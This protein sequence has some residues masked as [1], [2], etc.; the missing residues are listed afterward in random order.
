MAKDTRTYADR[1][2]YNIKAVSKRRKK[3]KEMAV[4]YKGGKCIVCNYSRYIG[5]LDFHHVDESDKEFSLSV[6]GLTR[7]WQRI[8]IE[9]DKCVLVC[10][11]CHREIHGGLINIKD[12][13]SG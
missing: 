11:N 2:E 4:L 1:R 7:S 12:F 3:L 6:N 13:L 10:S 9:L 5:A 8:Q